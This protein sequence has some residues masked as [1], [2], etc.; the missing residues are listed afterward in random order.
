VHGAELMFCFNTLHHS[1]RDLPQPTDND[2][3]LADIMSSV[4]AQFAHN[5]N[6]NI[7]GLPQWKPYTAKNGEMMLFDYNCRIMNNPDRELQ[8]IINKHCFKQLD[9]FQKKAKGTAGTLHD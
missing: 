5:G 9:D 6:P 2:L 4:W 8:Q 3:K 7:Q 1:K